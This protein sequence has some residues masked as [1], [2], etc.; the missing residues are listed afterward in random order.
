MVFLCS[1]CTLRASFLCPA[2]YRC[3]QGYKA[4]TV[5]HF[6]GIK[7]AKMMF[8]NLM[9]AAAP[10]NE[11]YSEQQDCI[12]LWNTA[13][14]FPKPGKLAQLLF[15]TNNYFLSTKLEDFY[16]VAFHCLEPIAGAHASMMVCLSSLGAQWLCK[17]TAE[18]LCSACTLRASFL[19]PAG[20]R[21]TQ[22]YKAKTV[23]HLV[24]KL[25]KWYS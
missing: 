23:F 11:G 8:I 22:G 3:T 20:Y 21:C 4:K 2:G 19:N 18:F 17:K 6:N 25:Q 9:V 24:Y 13:L 16:Y 15:F 12:P 1:A 5:F 14:S 7:G 10:K